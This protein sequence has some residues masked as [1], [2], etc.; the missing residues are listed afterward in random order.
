[1]KLSVAI[2]THNEG[3]HYL[4]PLFK[5]IG[6]SQIAT[7]I[8]TNDILEIVVID[9]NSKNP[10]TLAAIETLKDAKVVS[11]ALN[12]DFAAHK[13][14]MNSQCSG[15][16]ILNL[17]ADE[18]LDEHLLFNLP[19]I[20]ESNPSVDAY[21]IPRVNTVDGLTLAHVQKWGWVLSTMSGYS[22]VKAMAKDDP[23]YL[24][25][26][27]YGYILNEED[28]W[29]T[30]NRPIV[31]WPDPQMRLYRNDASIRWENKVHERLTGVN[32]YSMFPLSAEYAIQHHKEIH[33]QE[34]QNSFYETLSL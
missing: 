16:W 32:Q 25:L 4:D 22:A 19:S 8:Y 2:C 31:A 14:F 20:I 28:E 18:N 9:D 11:H 10:E 29:V 30:F 3:K 15:D 17:D 6:R 34:R 27:A 24:L 23:E 21:W 13:N 33:R 7:A 1:M 26:Q 5:T 12:G